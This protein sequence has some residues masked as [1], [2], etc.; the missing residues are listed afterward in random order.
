MPNHSSRPTSPVTAMTAATV[1]ALESRRMLSASVVD[2]QLRVVGT[3]AAEYLSIQRV[4]IGGV[5]K[6]EVAEQLVLSK[7][8]NLSRFDA[9]AITNGIRVDARNGD[10]V[11]EVYS[12]VT[13]RTTLIGGSGN[14]TL[15]G[16]NGR[17]IL[18]GGAGFDLL[19]GRG[20]RDQFEGGADVDTADYA[21]RTANVSVTLDN[22]ANDGEVGEADNVRTDVENVLGGFGNDYIT[23]SAASNNLA[24][25]G[26]NDT[27]FGV[28][29]AGAGPDYITGGDGADN[30]IAPN[31]TPG[32]TG[33]ILS[34]GAGNDHLSGGAGNDQ[35]YGG[36][37]HDNLYGY[38]GNDALY[39]E[40]GIDFLDGDTGAD[41]ISGGAGFDRV[42]YSYRSAR[43]W[44]TIDNR[45]NDGEALEN[46]NVL[47][48]V[49]RVDGG[50]GDDYMWGGSEGNTFYG[51]GGRDN[52]YGNGGNDYLSGGAGNDYLVGGAGNDVLDSGTGNDYLVATDGTS[53]R[54]YYTPTVDTVF[55]DVWD[56]RITQP[57]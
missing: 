50:S 35:L 12:S 27:I 40:D 43:L 48:D 2:G 13:N 53:D 19:D 49:E 44:I 23:G 55:L 26:G 41:Y 51:N 36:A 17:D 10:D 18:R 30:L 42:D 37:D 22:I 25:R 8:I 14:D 9:A 39:G 7:T 28:G 5:T 31:V 15:I 54:V 46:D 56:F 45:A 47:F 20:N 57:A 29:G 24:G 33:G 21:G 34:G 38:A 6:L 3:D 32:A 52:L 11:V 4:S 1:E 16:G